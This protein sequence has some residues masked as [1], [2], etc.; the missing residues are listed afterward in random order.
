MEN[1]TFYG[2]DI[3]KGWPHTERTVINTAVPGGTVLGPSCL[4]D[5]PGIQKA[6]KEGQKEENTDW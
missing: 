4:E 5:F 3:T 6:K 2:K 1:K